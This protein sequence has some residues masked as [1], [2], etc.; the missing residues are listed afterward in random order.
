MQDKKA[1]KRSRDE[2]SKDHWLIPNSRVCIISHK[3]EGNYYKQKAL[4]LD[5]VKPG[6][7]T[8]TMEGHIIEQVKEKYLET[9]LPKIGMVVVI[10]AGKQK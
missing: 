10:L 4:V 9:A 8:L 3:V 6:V 7:G 1:R 2:L 5:T